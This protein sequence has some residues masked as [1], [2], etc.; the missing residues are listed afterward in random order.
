MAPVPVRM[1]KLQKWHQNKVQVVLVLLSFTGIIPKNLHR[2]I[3]HVELPQNICTAPKKS[4]ITD[5]T[6][7][8]LTMVAMKGYNLLRCDTV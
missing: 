4:V 5:V 1:R 7:E 8:I 2:R 3:K 6:F